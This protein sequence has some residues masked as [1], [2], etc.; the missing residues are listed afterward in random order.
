MKESLDVFLEGYAIKRV[1]PECWS[2]VL[3]VLG[4]GHPATA[5]I[6]SKITKIDQPGWLAVAGLL[7]RGTLPQQEQLKS[8]GKAQESEAETIAEAE[9]LEKEQAK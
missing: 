6:H 1:L 3:G 8:P 2:A 5:N 4:R 9:K 7:G